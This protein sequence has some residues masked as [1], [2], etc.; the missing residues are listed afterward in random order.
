MDVTLGT[1][2]PVSL[3]TTT[4][5]FARMVIAPKATGEPR[6]TVDFKALNNASKRQTHKNKFP[7]SADDKDKITFIAPWGGFRY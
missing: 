3:N 4:T 2:E 5:W 7:F 6:R 1:I